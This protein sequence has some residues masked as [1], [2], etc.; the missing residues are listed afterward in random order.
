MNK[1][2]TKNT[3]NKIETLNRCAPEEQILTFTH[4]PEL[5]ETIFIL[6]EKS[7]RSF[8]FIRAFQDSHIW[9][10]RWILIGGFIFT[11]EL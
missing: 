1:T 7:H 4:R 11:M 6:Y 9:S 10:A 5:F 2:K 8:S 3:G